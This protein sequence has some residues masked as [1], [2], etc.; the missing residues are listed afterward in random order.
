MARPGHAARGARGGRRATPTRGDAAS[1]NDPGYAV[2]G[3]SHRAVCYGLR[4]VHARGAVLVLPQLRCASTHR[5][6]EVVRDRSEMR[7][8]QADAASL[9]TARGRLALLMEPGD[10]KTV[11]AETALLD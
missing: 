11:T 3:K 1:G 7:A 8:Y 2:Y 4:A 9:A 6:G 10:G 5:A